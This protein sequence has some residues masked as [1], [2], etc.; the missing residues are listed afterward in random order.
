MGGQPP[1]LPSLNEAENR[2]PSVPQSITLEVLA[3]VPTDMFHCS[4][5]DRLIDV[6]GIG[7]PVHQEIQ[8]TYPPEMLTE[9]RR[10]AIWLQDL[11]ARYGKRFYIRI[12]D[13]QSLKGLLMSVRYWV[14]RYPGFII[15]HRKRY[16]GRE[17]AALDRLLAQQ[18]FPETFS[19]TEGTSGN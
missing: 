18:I 4:H 15:N 17:P 8:A 10:L 7:T 3:H 14:R 12:V 16:V 11:S 1:T 9:A 5:C 13:P 6:A 19:E 2:M